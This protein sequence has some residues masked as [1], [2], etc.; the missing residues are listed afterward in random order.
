MEFIYESVSMYTAEDPH[1]PS[2]HT[3]NTNCDHLL[4]PEMRLF[5]SNTRYRQS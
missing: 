5:R 4:D 2:H 3:T 1:A